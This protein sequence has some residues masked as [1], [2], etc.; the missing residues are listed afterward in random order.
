MEQLTVLKRLSESIGV[1]GTEDEVR[2]IVLE[3]AT[4]LADEISTDVLGNVI[5]IRRGT[6]PEILMLDSHMDEV[7]FMVALIESS[8]FI[9]L[10]PIGG[11][12]PRILLAQ[13]V[14]I[15]TR[16]RRSIRGVIGTV[17]PHMLSEDDRKRPVAIEQMFV[18]VGATSD[19]DVADMGV[20]IGDVCVPT[21]GF[22]QLGDDLVMGKAFDDRAGCTVGLSVMDALAGRDLDMSVAFTFTIGEEVGLRGART[23][24]ANLRPSIALAL[25]GTTAVDIPGVSALRRATTLGAGPAITIADP[26]IF[27]DRGVIA[28]LEQVGDQHGIKY[29]HKVPLYGG[30]TNAGAIHLVGGGCRAGVVSVPCRYLHTPLTL[31]RPSDLAAAASLV[32]A[33]ALSA[34]S[35]L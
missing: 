8:G 9:R 29:Q 34:A 30:S 25:E 31:L 16:D 21:Y 5:A 33:F 14:T 18:D 24:T 27:A 19:A 32:E 17:P 10:A 12:D 26:S 15:R 13:A 2:D 4:P 35:L 22:E 11:W 3:Y 1:S 6:R 7:G 23:A 28:L 20:R